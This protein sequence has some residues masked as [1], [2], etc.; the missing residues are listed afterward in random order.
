MQGIEGFYDSDVGDYA[1]ETVETLRSIGAHRT[2]EILLELN[3]AF[4]GGAPDHDRERRRVQ[5]DELRAQQSAPLDDY[6]QQLRAAVDELDG[7]PERYLFA[8]Q[9][10]FSSDA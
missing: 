4:S 8:H 1:A 2:A 5:L 9:H 6:E 7:L 10:K 3:H